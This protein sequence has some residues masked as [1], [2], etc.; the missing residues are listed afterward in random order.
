[1]LL[2]ALVCFQLVQG[3]SCDPLLSKSI[4]LIKRRLRTARRGNYIGV[5]ICVIACLVWKSPNIAYSAVTMVCPCLHDA[6]QN[7][8]SY[9]TLVC[10]A[11]CIKCR[12][13]QRS[14][15]PAAPLQ[16]CASVVIELHALMVCLCKAL[17]RHKVLWL[18]CTISAATCSRFL[19]SLFT[20]Y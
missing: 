17:R 19:R 6:S 9:D 1:M 10:A 3:L 15:T 7:T 2:R 4:M 14:Q 11:F 20:N 8:A 12:K 13:S 5:L 16:A 18:P